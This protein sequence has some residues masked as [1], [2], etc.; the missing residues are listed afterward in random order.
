MK[1][2]ES[3]DIHNAIHAMRL[4]RSNTL[5]V[6]DIENVVR[7]YDA[8]TFKLLSG[9]KSNVE[10]GLSYVN[11]LG[12][13][14]DGKHMLFYR[15]SK[16][17]LLLF[18][19]PEK[20]FLASIKAHRAGTESVCFSPDGTAFVTGGVDG[21]IY[22]WSVAGGKK[23]DTFPHHSD[24]VCVIAF[25]P[26]SRLVATAGYD[27]IIKVS[28]RSFR[29]NRYRLISHQAIPTTLTF[30]SE[31]RLLS[32]DREGTLLV[33]DITDSKVIKRLE[34][35]PSHITAVALS[36]NERFLFVCG[37]QGD[38]GLYDLREGKQLKQNYLHTLSSITSACFSDRD[39][40]LICGLVNGTIVVYDF[41]EEAR[42]FEGFLKEKAFLECYRMLEEDPMLSY[43]P[44]A[45][46]LEETF[47]SHYKGARKLLMQDET[48]KAATLMAPFK[49]S[50]AKRLVI[51]KL[52][53]DF[54]LY[55]RF[56]E[57]ARA[58]RFATA[59]ALAEEYD[60][61]K[62]TPLYEA[63]EK[64]WQQILLAVRKIPVSKE[65][66]AK[67]RQLFKPYLGVPGKNIVMNTLY[68]DG[69]TV[70]LFQKLIGNREYTEAFKMIA[71]HP[72]LK[73]L[74]EYD[75]LIRVGE[76]LESKMLEAFQNGRYPEAVHISGEL[77]CFPDRAGEAARIRER[78]N[79]YAT[80]MSYYAEKKIAEVYNIIEKHPYL[81]EAEIG[82][83]VEK[84]FKEALAETEQH[85]ARCDVAA[86]KKSM[87]RFFKVRSKVPSIVHIIKVA[88]L[89]QLER[90]CTRQSPALQQAVERYMGYFGYDEMLDD[91][92]SQF[93]GMCSV[94]PARQAE[95][96]EYS[97][98]VER[99]PDR[100][101]DDGAEQRS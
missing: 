76:L 2:S 51:Q 89:G 8:G 6:A 18:H 86:I 71:A 72:F 15:S 79:A 25:S 90:L 50:G 30:L 70:Q 34:K 36:C 7:N 93:E 17:E 98:S 11:N 38:I 80:A 55:K 45:E 97:G 87:E 85:A 81:A 21:R 24:T 32:T 1:I 48:G 60:G 56:A 31:Q 69:T 101:Y 61:L 94:T 77:A 82:T 44:L 73:N 23:I 19:V 9:F 39:N 41:A 27:R 95:A 52:F 26:D 12:I 64:K 42:K 54:K 3:I 4:H 14:E 58:G 43:N 16:K 100:L 75:K 88:Y 66:E 49:S 57:S 91:E 96:R 92:L 22:M 62:T 28:N 67:L 84:A 74:D 53:N 63:M 10:K 29:N 40:R 78:A 47:E 35:F 65:Y 20:K 13:S 33:W 46:T 68:S 37:M 59:Y 99:L 5:T 83:I